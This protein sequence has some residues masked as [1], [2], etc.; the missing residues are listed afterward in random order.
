MVR[1]TGSRE[2][3]ADVAGA[4]AAGQ[5]GHQTQKQMVQERRGKSRH[6]AAKRESR[7]GRSGGSWK[8]KR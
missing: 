1:S 6:R 4:P 3:Q 7:W 5:M 2:T 8:A